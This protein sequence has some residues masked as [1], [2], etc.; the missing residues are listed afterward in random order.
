[1]TLREESVRAAKWPSTLVL[2]M[3]DVASFGGADGYHIINVACTVVGVRASHTLSATMHGRMTA[4][5]DV[6]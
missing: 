5:N 3:I 2:P 6:P 4:L 1:M